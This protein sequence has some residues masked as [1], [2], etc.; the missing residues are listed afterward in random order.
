MPEAEEPQA[1]TTTGGTH[2]VEELIAELASAEAGLLDAASRLA[3]ATDSLGSAGEQAASAFAVLRETIVSGSTRLAFERE[4]EALARWA[5]RLEAADALVA[6]A[7]HEQRDAGARFETALA[8]VREEIGDRLSELTESFNAFDVAL[9]HLGSEADALDDA[10]DEPAG[11]LEQGLTVVGETA[12]ALAGQVEASTGQLAELLGGLG[13]ILDE[14]SVGLMADIEADLQPSSNPVSSLESEVTG[15]LTA[16][17][18]DLE[19]AGAEAID[20]AVDVVDSVPSRWE[21]PLA[22]ATDSADQTVDTQGVEMFEE[23]ERLMDSLRSAVE[24]TAAWAPILPQLPALRMM[25]ERISD[26]FESM[27]LG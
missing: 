13:S 5:E 9:A 4:G 23:L 3:S 7:E 18:D 25:L 14:G 17:V 12:E 19:A 6:E 22:A 1:P 16:A 10:L 26:A 20:G 24:V 15:L 8:S 21:G 11:R 27:D 2:D